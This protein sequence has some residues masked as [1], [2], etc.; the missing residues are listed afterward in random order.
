MI[1]GQKRDEN[2]RFPF[3]LLLV[4]DGEVICTNLRHGES[5]KYWLLD[6]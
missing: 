4:I 5:P 6:D 2:K 1:R 3:S